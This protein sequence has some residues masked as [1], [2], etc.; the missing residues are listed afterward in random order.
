LPAHRQAAVG[1][2]L[3]AEIAGHPV[4]DFSNT[5]AG[6]DGAAT[7]EYLTDDDHLLV[8]ARVEGLLPSGHVTHLR[9]LARRDPGAAGCSSTHARA[10][11]GARWPSA[12]NRATVQ[13]FAERRR[14]GART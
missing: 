13:R 8:F 6:W 1:H 2:V 14:R 10:V 7:R 3:P 5:W 11:A 9:G 4:L 12:A